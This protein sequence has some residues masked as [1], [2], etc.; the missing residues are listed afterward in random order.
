MSV[1]ENHQERREA[2]LSKGGLAARE[3]FFFPCGQQQRMAVRLSQP[4]S[5]TR[6]G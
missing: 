1:E 3:P 2:V 5:S 4:Y 6:T